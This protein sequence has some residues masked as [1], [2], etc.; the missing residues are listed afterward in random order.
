VNKKHMLLESLLPVHDDND[1]VYY[2]LPLL[3]MPYL[4]WHQA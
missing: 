4:N 2:H 3:V 1:R